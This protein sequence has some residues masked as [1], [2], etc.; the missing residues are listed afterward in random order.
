MTDFYIVIIFIKIINM[1][2]FD[3]RWVSSILG[4]EMPIL[5]DFESHLENGVILCQLG[6]KY[7]AEYPKWKHIYD[8]HEANYKVFY[9]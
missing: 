8:R 4:I 3:Y 9:T 6:E 2:I 7:M 1:Y 5:A